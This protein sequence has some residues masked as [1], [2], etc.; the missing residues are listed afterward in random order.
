MALWVPQ[1]Y[2][3][4][5]VPRAAGQPRWDPETGTTIDTV[6]A[7]D[8]PEPVPLWEHFGYDMVGAGGWFDWMPRRGHSEVLEETDEWVV[9]RNGAGA[10]FQHWKKRSGPPGPVD[11]LMTSREIWERDYRPHL[12]ELDPARVDVE[13]AREQFRQA[14][15]AGRWVFFG[16]MFV[17]EILRASLGDE[18][19]YVNLLQDPEWIRDY[20]RVYTEFYKKHYAYLFEQ[21]GLPDGI[22]V[23]EDLAYNSGLLA[24]PQVLADLIFPGYR[25]LNDFFHGHGLPVILHSDGRIGQAIPMIIAAGFA[26]LNPIERKTPENDPFTFAERY[27]DQLLF[28]GGLDARVYETNDRAVIRREVTA[29][30]QG[31]K[32]RGA[33]LLF[34]TDHTISPHTRYDSYRY[35]LDVYREQ[36]AY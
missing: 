7:G 8:Y 11:F 24:S 1:G 29:Y 3:T 14:R 23:Y 4:R 28:V 6:A 13:G 12:L 9:K 19:M 16:H 17:W 18:A 15:A 26:G 27:G 32:A 30:L 25:E 5:A 10:A 34:A 31:M 36:M 22:W 2:P 20:T 33:R 21:V 35:A